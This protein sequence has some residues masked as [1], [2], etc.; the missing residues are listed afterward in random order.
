MAHCNFSFLME[1]YKAWRGKN[2]SGQCGSIL[3]EGALGTPMPE[4]S[5][6]Y[7]GEDRMEGEGSRV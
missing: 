5:L 4:P 3:E 2:K 7:G 6:P 1:L